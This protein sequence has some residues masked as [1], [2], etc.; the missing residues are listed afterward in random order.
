[1]TEIPQQTSGD[2]KDS[3]ALMFGLFAED[4]AQ[5]AGKASLLFSKLIFS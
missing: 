3:A 2:L 4:Y 1:L 5:Q